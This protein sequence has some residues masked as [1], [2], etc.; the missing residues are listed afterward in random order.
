MTGVFCFTGSGHSLRVAEYI[1]EK[2]NSSVCMIDSKKPA[3]AEELQSAVVVFPVYCQNIPKPV[4]RFLTNLKAEN[5]VLIASYGKISWGNVLA[6]AEKLVNGSVIAGACVPIGHTFLNGTADFD[7]AALEPLFE[8]I[9]SPREAKIP[10]KRK[11]IF[12]DFLPAWRSRVSVK[13]I[14]ADSCTLCDLCGR[15]CP[16]S[17]IKNGITN[18]KCIRCLRCVS[19]CP[20]KALS[21]KNSFVLRRYL[22]KQRTEK[23]VEL[24][25]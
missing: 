13:I 9:E 20:Q 21:F 22:T 6:E 18:E 14:R 5:I 3:S 8:R 25:L 16:M 11:N 10:V 1:A 7:K 15:S 19:I 4:K 24:F 23:A 2:L 12:A 17:A